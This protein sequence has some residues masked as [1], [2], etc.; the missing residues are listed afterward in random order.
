[1]EVKINKFLSVL[2]I[3]VMFNMVYRIIVCVSLRVFCFLREVNWF[4]G[5]VGFF[6]VM[7]KKYGLFVDMLVLFFC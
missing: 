2:R 3:L 1:M 5:F 4:V 7:F 6:M